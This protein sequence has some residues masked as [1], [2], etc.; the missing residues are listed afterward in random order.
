MYFACTG[1]A[2]QALTSSALAAA[3]AIPLLL[4][5]LWFMRGRLGFDRD[6]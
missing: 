5:A 4:G 2:A 3:T 1:D 6:G